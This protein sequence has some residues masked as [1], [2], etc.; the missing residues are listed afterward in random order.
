ML[1]DYYPLLK[2]SHIGLALLSEGLFA[3]RGLGVLMGASLPMAP[4]MRSSMVIDSALLAAALLPLAALQ[5]QPLAAPW[6]QVK[7]ALLVGYIVFGTL[8]LRRARTPTGRALAFVAALT[9]Y[10]LIIAVARSHD[11]STGLF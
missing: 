7:L 6:L 4:V 10:T 3:G 9:C 11:P 1:V 5:F 2:A 8:A